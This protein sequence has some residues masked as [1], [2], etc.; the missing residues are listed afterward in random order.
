MI[1]WASNACRTD[2]E[3][4]TIWRRLPTRIGTHSGRGQA[5]QPLAHRDLGAHT[6]GV[7]AVARDRVEALAVLVEQ[8]SRVCS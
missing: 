1:P 4:F 6:F 3:Y 2:V 8:S 7:V 5:D